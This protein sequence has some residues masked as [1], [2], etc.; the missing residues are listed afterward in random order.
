MKVPTIGSWNF[1]F[2]LHPSFPEHELTV[3]KNTQT[4]EREKRSMPSI[5]HVPSDDEEF[6][7]ASESFNVDDE[8]FVDNED[9][10]KKQEPLSELECKVR[11]S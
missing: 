1:K 5:V 4:R 8:Y 6:E 3:R 10:A 7:D 2:F 11:F 9:S